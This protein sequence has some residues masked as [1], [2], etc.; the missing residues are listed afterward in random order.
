MIVKVH[1]AYRL[2]VAVCDDELLG[3]KFEEGDKQI[4]LT[5]SFFQG[6]KKT[7]DE[8]KEILKDMKMEDATF[9]IVGKNSCESALNL[10][11]IKKE[12]ISE[13]QGVP[14]ALILL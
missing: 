11:I 1:D 8:T 7:S 3:K 4:D 5:G 13:I 12:G 10:G 14:I 9:N 2:V 6:T